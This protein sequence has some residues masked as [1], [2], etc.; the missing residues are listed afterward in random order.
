[1]LCGPA[2]RTSPACRRGRSHPSARRR[3][4]SRATRSRQRRPRRSSSRPSAR[5]C[6][7]SR[8]RGTP[9]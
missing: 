4:A 5:P 7:C 6:R 8:S 9:S 3:A 1:V 2:V